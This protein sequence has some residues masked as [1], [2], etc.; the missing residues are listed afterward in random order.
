MTLRIL[1]RNLAHC[2][3]RRDVDHLLG[4]AMQAY[5]TGQLRRC[6]WEAFGDIALAFRPCLLE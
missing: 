2:L 5:E 3:F 1:V 6:D 4:V